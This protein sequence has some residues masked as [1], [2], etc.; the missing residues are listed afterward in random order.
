MSALRERWVILLA[1][2]DGR[3][4]LGHTVEGTRL[5]RPKQ[6]CRIGDERSLLNRALER[7]RRLT[8]PERIVPVVC[9]R[10]RIWWGPELM[11]LPPDHVLEQPENRGNAVAVL[12]ALVHILQHDPD[13]RVA[14]VPSDHAVEDEEVLVLAI[15]DALRHV[16][17]RRGHVTL[18]G[19]MP[20]EPDEGYGWIVPGREASAFRSVRAFIEKPSRVTAAALMRHGALW[21]SFVF[22]A[23]GTA[24]VNLFRRTQPELLDSYLEN[25]L[26]RGWGP[27]AWSAFYEELEPLDFSRDLLEHAPEWLDVRPVE[28]CGWSDLGTPRRVDQWLGRHGT[29]RDRRQGV[30]SLV[31]TW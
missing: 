8:E 10:H 6:F 31:N 3:R 16:G 13:P 7:A 26:D 18:L 1:G 15:R 5:D 28:P 19:I 23:T 17:V 27:G 14:V 22:A 11:D 30:T 21:N 2:G 4:L 12:H 25:L 29:R 24:L 9:A 20:E